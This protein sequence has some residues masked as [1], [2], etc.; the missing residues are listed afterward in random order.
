MNDGSSSSQYIES[1]WVEGSE[2]SP[3]WISVNIKLSTTPTRPNYIFVGWSLDW[4]HYDYQNIGNNDT[5]G[6]ETESISVLGGREHTL[7]AIWMGV[8]KTI[9]A[10]MENPAF[11]CCSGVGHTGSKYLYRG[12]GRTHS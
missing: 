9:T 6:A 7:Y 3:P 1:G 2:N 11:E 8:D 4:K 5:Y 10:Y 12:R